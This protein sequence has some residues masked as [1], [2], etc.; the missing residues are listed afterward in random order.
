VSGDAASAAPD[1]ASRAAGSR[2]PVS[3][4]R[5]PSY[6]LAEV[7]RA[8]AEAFELAGGLEVSGASVLVKPNMLNA[9]A[10]ARAIT[11]HPALLSSLVRLLKARGAARIV[12][13]DS[14]GIP[15]LESA[16]RKTGLR[17]AAEEAGASWTELDRP[18]RVD[19]PAGKR[20]RSFEFGAAFAEADLLVSLAK[21]K[22]HRLVYFTGAIKN[23]LGLVPGLGKS[24]FHLRFPDPVDFGEML[25]DLAAA[26]K[27]AF[28][29]MD[30]VL[31]MEGPGPSAGRPKELGL[32]MAS[33]D[34]AALDWSCA[35]LVGYDPWRIPYLADAL[36]RGVWVSRPD[37]IE[38]LGE[39]L[40]SARPR[41]FAL[42]PRHGETDF[43]RRWMPGFFH[44]AFRDILVPRPFF[45]EAAC[46]LCGACVEICPPKALRIERA[47]NGGGRILID[48]SACIRCYCCDEVCP[49]NAI[50]LRRGFPSR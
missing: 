17:A 10:P 45:D 26:A 19:Y 9:A 30:A 8:L 12:V 28:S 11:T 48:R 5:C 46:A 34:P 6:D 31:A 32:V 38:I 2:V 21:L 35:S 43:F 29:V 1:S 37:Q 15:S 13:G 23:L 33:R 4:A 20:V 27:P 25:V 44:S 14:A 47:G 3:I 40:E 50:R 18:T 36:S 22:T 49:R 42:V 39:S 16:S 41:T 7:D 24:A